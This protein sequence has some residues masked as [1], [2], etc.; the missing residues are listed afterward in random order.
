MIDFCDGRF[1]NLSAAGLPQRTFHCGGTEKFWSGEHRER[2]LDRHSLQTFPYVWFLA[3]LWFGGCGDWSADPFAWLP[4]D[5]RFLLEDLVHFFPQIVQVHPP[6]RAR[7]NALSDPMLDRLIDGV[8]RALSLGGG[9]MS[10]LIGLVAAH[11]GIRRYVEVGGYEGGSML[12]LALR[13]LNRDIDFYSVESFAGNKDGAM[14]G[15]PL[16]SRRKYMANRARYPGLRLTLLPADSA[17]AATFFDDGSLDCVFIDACHETPSVL[18]DIDVWQPK[19][20][21]GGM[22]AGDD[23]GWPSVRAAVEQRFAQVNATPSG[24]VWWLRC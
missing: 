13:F 8:P 12:T 22:L 20:A 23:Y 3:M 19:L 15:W 2:V 5:S 11:R 18:S 1:V 16:P 6:A 14:D 9:S 4:P 10:E 7:W 17:H 21:A 24:C